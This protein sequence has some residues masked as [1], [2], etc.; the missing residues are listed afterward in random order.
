MNTR[1][2]T[3]TAAAGLLAAAAVL[4]TSNAQALPLGRPDPATTIRPV[5]AN[6]RETVLRLL[7]EGRQATTVAQRRLVHHD[8]VQ[9]VLDGE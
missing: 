4:T 6:L 5:P 3:R 9:S 2:A 1:T 8:L 7:D